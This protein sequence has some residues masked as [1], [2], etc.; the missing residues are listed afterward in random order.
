MKADAKKASI[1]KKKKKYYEANH[2]KVKSQSKEIY[3]KNKDKRKSQFKDY[4]EANRSER[5]RKMTLYNH[6][7]RLALRE[8]MRAL[9]NDRISKL[10]PSD[11]IKNFKREIVDGLN[12]V[13]LSCQRILFRRSV[14][15]LSEKE[16]TT[17]KEKWTHER[18]SQLLNNVDCNDKKEVI[19]MIDDKD[20]LKLLFAGAYYN[21]PVEKDT[22]ASYM[23]KIMKFITIH[24]DIMD[25]ADIF[26]HSKYKR[27]LVMD[28][29]GKLAGQISRRDV[30]R[31]I[32]E[33]NSNTW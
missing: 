28:D 13:C 6:R 14:K 27:L 29:N 23:D 33:M 26:L 22:V 30:V 20:C 1:I 3:E 5:L 24:E 32:K 10:T 17:L 25:V 31:A 18:L 2:E 11:R 8:K 19:G 21:Q 12:F 9:R 4:H 15:F 7:N 16:I